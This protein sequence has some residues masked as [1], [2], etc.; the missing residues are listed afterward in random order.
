MKQDNLLRCNMDEVN[1]ERALGRVEGKI[2]L[3]VK[4]TSELKT[5]FATLE[6]GRLSRLETIV[7]GLVAKVSIIAAAVPIAVTIVWGLIQHF[8]LK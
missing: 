6:A 7:A 2:D 3:V 4:D 1:V 8:L 5:A